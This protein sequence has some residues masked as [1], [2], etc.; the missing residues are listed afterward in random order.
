MFL[1][2]DVLES[3]LLSTLAFIWTI[4]LFKIIKVFIC[5]L[6]HV[7]TSTYTLASF[8]RR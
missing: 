6:L 3:D 5:N 7:L 8:L 4:L 2:V 1:L